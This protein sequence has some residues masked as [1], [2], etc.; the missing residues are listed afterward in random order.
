MISTIT[1]TDFRNHIQSRV[2]TNGARNIIII[3]ENGGGKTALMEAVSQLSHGASLRGAALSDMARMGGNGGFSV[4][5]ELEDGTAISISFTGCDANRKI[6]ID[7]NVANASDLANTIRLVWLTPREDR[8]FA[9]AGASD[10]RGFFDRMVAGF[11]AKHAGRTARL[12]KLLSERAFALKNSADDAWVLPIEK[13]LAATAAAVAAARVKYAGE[14][15]FML[16]DMSQSRIAL[17]GWFEERMAAG[18]SASDAER[19]YIAHLSANRDLVSDRMSIDGA[20]RSDFGIWNGALQKQARMTSTG[21]QKS[22]LLEWILAHA[23]LT[24]AKCGAAPVILLDEAAA[25]LD[26]RAR[27][28]LFRQLNDTGAQVWMTGIDAELFSG[29]PDSI[30]VCCREGEVVTRDS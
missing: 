11:D 3:G 22:V 4:N 2:R 6:R 25:H 20:H 15:N 23:R 9:D 5:A 13:H 24:A 14:V 18:A 19:E 28:N 27:E 12:A 29:I 26:A 21:Q 30:F 1:I 10:R 17:S 16:A 7:G 8:L